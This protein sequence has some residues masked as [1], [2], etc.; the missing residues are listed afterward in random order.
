MPPTFTPT[1]DHGLV[2]SLIA[3]SGSG[4]DPFPESISTVT[5]GG[6]VATHSLVVGS[7][8]G[9]LSGNITVPAQEPG[10][11]TIVIAGGL[12]GSQTFTDVY[13]VDTP[14]PPTLTLSPTTGFIG[15]SVNATGGDWLIGET[16]TS[17][18]VGGTET[19]HSLVIDG[20]GDLS[21]AIDIPIMAHG[22]KDV[23]VTGSVSGAK[24]FTSAL[25]VKVLQNSSNN[26]YQTK[27]IEC[28]ILNSAA[29]LTQVD[30]VGNYRYVVPEALHGYKLKTCAAHVNVV[31]SSGTPTIQIHS[32]TGDYDM[33]T[34]ALTIDENEKDSAGATVPA[35]IDTADGHDVLSTG[36]EIRFDCDVAG[37]GAQGLSI[38]FTVAPE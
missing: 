18:K 9:E 16:I 30:E 15:S 14:P 2:G 8:T 25:S 28:H 4:W 6:N 26:A 3:A 5:V 33:L 23:V 32:V 35:V 12:S 17:V 21:G 24:T 20:S 31:S 7:G 11:K 29:S 13:T 10:L 1:P 34:T 37:T 38:R 22:P 19:S 27:T 36:Q